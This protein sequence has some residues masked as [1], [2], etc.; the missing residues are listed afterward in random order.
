MYKKVSIEEELPP[1]DV[2]VTCFYDSGETMVYKRIQ[3][4]IITLT[5]DNTIDP[6]QEQPNWSWTRRDG[7]ADRTPKEGKITHWL[8]DEGDSIPY[9]VDTIFLNN[10]DSIVVNLGIVSVE[11]TKKILASALLDYIKYYRDCN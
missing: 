1:I 9:P 2:F 3:S 4:A 5:V 7:I 8:K 10:D 11:T 6:N